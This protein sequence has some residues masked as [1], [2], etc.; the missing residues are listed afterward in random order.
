M[1]AITVDMLV[2]RIQNVELPVEQRVLDAPLI[3]RRSVGLPKSLLN[4][5][6]IFLTV[7]IKGKLL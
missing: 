7:N 4:K 2:D 5:V 1:G 6:R 3:L